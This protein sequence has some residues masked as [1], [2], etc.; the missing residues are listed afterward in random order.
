MLTKIYQQSGNATQEGIREI[1]AAIQPK[2]E[3]QEVVLYLKQKG[4]LIYLISGAIDMYVK[5]VAKKLGVSGFYANSSLAF[6]QQGGLEKIHYRNN[7]G[8]VKVEQLKDLVKKFGI[9]TN[10]AVFVGDSE[11]DIE[12]FKETGHGI[13]VHATSEELKHVAWR[14]IESLQELYNIL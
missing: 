2:P 6:N 9:G 1:F 3:A 14:E 4:Y 8:E 12:V 10:E 7:Q 11:N 5:E 13:A